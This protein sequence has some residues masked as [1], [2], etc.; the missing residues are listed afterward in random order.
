MALVLVSRYLASIKGQVCYIS[1]FYG[2]LAVS[3]CEK[4][5]WRQ[6]PVSLGRGSAEWPSK[7]LRLGHRRFFFLQ[8]AAGF[9]IYGLWPLVIDV[10]LSLIGQSQTSREF[11]Q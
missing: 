9:P 11:H 4:S 6:T 7:L 1:D 3:N 10:P 8:H 2:Q 5:Y